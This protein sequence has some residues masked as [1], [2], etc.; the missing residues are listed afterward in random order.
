MAGSKHGAGKRGAPKQILERI[1]D[2]HRRRRENGSAHFIVA[3]EVQELLRWGHDQGIDIGSR[4][5]RERLLARVGEPERNA[6]R[7]AL[8][9]VDLYLAKGLAQHALEN[10]GRRLRQRL[11]GSGTD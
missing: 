3:V 5:V 6:D 7:Y 4:T 10:I 11:D 9:L 8:N 2:E 1:W